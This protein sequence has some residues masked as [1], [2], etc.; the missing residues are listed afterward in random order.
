MDWLVRVALRV[1]AAIKD[2]DCVGLQFDNELLNHVID[3][4]LADRDFNRAVVFPSREF[5]LDENECALHEAFG[6]R[7]KTFPVGNDVVP[8]CSVL[9]L[10]LLVFPGLPSG[11]GNLTTGVPFARSLVSAFLPTYPTMVS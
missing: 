6:D 2:T 11:N 8:L 10:A 5:A 9:P 3:G 4:L 7:L 1:D